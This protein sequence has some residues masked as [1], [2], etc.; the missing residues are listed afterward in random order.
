MAID[1][2]TEA[3][4]NVL[5][6]WAHSYAGPTTSFLVQ[7]G[8]DAILLDVGCD[9]IGNIRRIGVAPTNVTAV[10]ISHMH[11]DHASGIANFIFTRQ[12]LGRGLADGIPTL[13]VIAHS[14][15]LD[16]VRELLRCQYPERAFT[17]DWIA[18]KTR[19]STT[20]SPTIALEIFANTHT[21]PCFGAVIRVSEGPTIAFTSDTAPDASHPTIIAGSDV[22][23]GECF[24]LGNLAGA[25]IHKRGH[26][27]AEDLAYLVEMISPRFV[28]PF[29]FDQKYND[30]AR[31]LDLLARCAGSSD[32]TIIDPVKQPTLAL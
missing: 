7:A 30:D 23:I 19:E 29:H 22:L 10:Y 24:D 8:S 13:K 1:R 28:I 27:T 3:K 18:P 21:V 6:C 17:L 31:R 4:V 20:L 9:P 12:L 16:G 2:N 25:D 15:V 26:S 11:S 32:T 14:N 5:G